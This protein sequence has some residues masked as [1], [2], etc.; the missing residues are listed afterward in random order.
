MSI[1]KFRVAITFTDDS[2]ITVEEE[3]DYQETKVDNN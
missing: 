1:T 2:K 3:L